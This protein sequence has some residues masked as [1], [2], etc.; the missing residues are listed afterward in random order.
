MKCPNCGAVYNDDVQFCINCGK[1]LEP[2][3]P[4][5]TY[6][7]TNKS[8]NTWIFV[9]IAIAI[10]TILVGGGVFW[11]F[12]QTA[13][14]APV[15]ASTN[16]QEQKES[17]SYECQEEESSSSEEATSSQMD[18]SNIETYEGPTTEGEGAYEN[19]HYVY[20]SA[21]DGYVNIRSSASAKSRILGALYNGGEGAFYLGQYGKWYKVDYN[22]IIGYC[23]ID[24][25][26][27]E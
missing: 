2:Q 23:H 21:Y 24:H 18:D 4:E 27:I 5:Q 15:I 9:A 17:N 16:T 26:H 8:T 13:Q 20:S 6:Y 25:C 10:T 22:G 19:E 11:Y 12:N 7:P 1:K 3:V 14:K